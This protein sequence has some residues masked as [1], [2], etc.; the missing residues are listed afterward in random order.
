MALRA[1]IMDLSIG[2]R[3]TASRPALI[4]IDKKVAFIALLFG[5]P[6][7]TLLRPHTVFTPPSCLI[8]GIACRTSFVCAGSVAMG[9]INGSK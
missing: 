9:L 1:E 6:K 4:A 2:S 5:S 7:E 8:S 3:M